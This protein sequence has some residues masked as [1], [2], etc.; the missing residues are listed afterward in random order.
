MPEENGSVDSQEQVVN[1]QETAPPDS[2]RHAKSGHYYARRTR[3]SKR[4]G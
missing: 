2:N 1:N 4:G 3:K